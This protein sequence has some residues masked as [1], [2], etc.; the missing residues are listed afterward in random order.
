M[1]RMNS[2]SGEQSPASGGGG[3][4]TQ[5]WR[6]KFERAQ[7]LAPLLAGAV[8]SLAASLPYLSTLQAYYL[9]DDFG[10]IQHFADKPLSHFVELFWQ[11]WAV[12]VWEKTLDEVRPLAAIL[13]K[14]G[15]VASTAPTGHHAI[16][17]A[18][19][20]VSSL[21]AMALARVAGQVSWKAATFAGLLFAVLPAHAEAVAWITGRADLLLALTYGTSLLTFAWW[22]R[23]PSAQYYVASLVAYA[24]ALYSK[25][26]AM[27]LPV[28]LACHDWRN[29]TSTGPRRWWPYL[30][31]VVLTLL[32]LAL[33]MFLFGQGV[34]E[35]QLTVSRLYEHVINQGNYLQSL[36]FGAVVVNKRRI[37]AVLLI[38]LTGSIAF[39]WYRYRFLTKWG[40]A[41]RRRAVLVFGPVWWLVTTAPL[42][43]ADYTTIRFLYL[44][45]L[46]MVV[47]AAVLIDDFFGRSEST[48]R[49][50]TAVGLFLL[51]FFAW[52]LRPAVRA[53][54]STAGVSETVVRVVAGELGSASSDTL[55]LVDVPEYGG[56]SQHPVWLW[57]W[58]VPY[59]L[60]PPFVEPTYTRGSFLLCPREAYFDRGRWRDHVKRVVSR[61]R[62]NAPEGGVVALRWDSD[63]GAFVRR[64][65][66]ELP[67]LPAW[68]A[69]MGQAST[70]DEM[71]RHWRGLVAR[72]Q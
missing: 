30:P 42:A 4:P 47:A 13:Y 69:Y 9:G 38:F 33:R 37:V 23:R 59:A 14:L 6:S 55:V 45:A 5:T 1:G 61:W 27:T 34:R 58:V 16:N 50:A 67:D 43:M 24:C 25:Q 54:T 7:W 26:P 63:S 57:A 32:M 53:W 3:A 66:R 19:H 52:R 65:S 10:F 28:I 48:R 60:Q 56:T 18:L 35:D 39:L 31:Y 36:L 70:D 44:P 11:P 62:S 2:Q 41:S 46:G 20:A 21:V 22:R 51:L 29:G 40:T 71:V 17:L 72:V 15:S 68:I 49:A 12:G 64:T 8:V